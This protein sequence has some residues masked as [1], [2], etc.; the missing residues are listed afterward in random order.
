MSKEGE[1]YIEITDTL[2]FKLAINP[3]LRKCDFIEICNELK[4]RLNTPENRIIKVIPEPIT[5]GGIKIIY[6][7]PTFYKCMRLGVRNWEW[8][9]PTTYDDWTNNTD[10]LLWKNYNTPIL[11]HWKKEPIRYEYTRLKAYKN[12]PIW[13][14]KELKIVKEVFEKHNL[15]VRCMPKNRDLKSYSNFLIHC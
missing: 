13:T 3:Q 9:H 12:A 6:E 1:E 14:L 2:G 4:E 5:E 10:L 8:I 7:N 15:K 11:T